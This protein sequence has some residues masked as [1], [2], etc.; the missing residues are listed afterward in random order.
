[1]HQVCAHNNFDVFWF[2]DVLQDQRVPETT[3]LGFLEVW[4]KIYELIGGT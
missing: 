1:M 2:Q 4:N 3:N